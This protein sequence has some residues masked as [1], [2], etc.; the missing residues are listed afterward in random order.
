MNR[1]CYLEMKGTYIQAVNAYSHDITGLYLKLEKIFERYFKQGQ[2]Q[3][4]DEFSFEIGLGATIHLKFYENATEIIG[5]NHI[6]EQEVKEILL[7]KEDSAKKEY[8]TLKGFGQSLRL[9][10]LA[11]GPHYTEHFYQ[12]LDNLKPGQM[13]SFEEGRTYVCK[14]KNGA[15]IE[16]LEVFSGN[17]ED[18]QLKNFICENKPIILNLHNDSIIQLFYQINRKGNTHSSEN[19]IIVLDK[20]RVKT[21]EIESDVSV[22]HSKTVDLGPVSF[23]IKQK[24]LD[25]CPKWYIKGAQI[26]RDTASFIMAY[27]STNPTITKYIRKESSE[28]KTA[29]D[30]EHQLTIEKLLNNKEFETAY[31]EMCD[32]TKKNQKDLTIYTKTFIKKENKY[33]ATALIFKDGKAYLAEFPNGYYKASPDNLQSLSL[34]QFKFWCEQ[35]Y[36]DT[37]Q[38]VFSKTLEEIQQKYSAVNENILKNQIHVS[39]KITEKKLKEIPDIIFEEQNFQFGENEFSDLVQNYVDNPDIS[40]LL[41]ERE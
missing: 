37:H 41:G 27:L 28:E 13:I 40:D 16:L 5:L 12:V 11:I 7:S 34:P 2:A 32:Y 30:A 17:I 39:E 26:S 19:D 6:N 24:I 33:I 31:Q 29:L 14:N 9:A 1:N 25:K 8:S 18:I 23:V 35:K 3:I 15:K 21:K 20:F 36:N 22:M 4:G 10:G 38:I